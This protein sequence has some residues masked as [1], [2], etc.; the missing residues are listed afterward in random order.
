MS[1][2]VISFNRSFHMTGSSSSSSHAAPPSEEKK[3]KDPSISGDASLEEASDNSAAIDA[4]SDDV[5]FIIFSY[6][7]GKGQNGAMLQ[8]LREVSPRWYRI[9]EEMFLRDFFWRKMGTDPQKLPLQ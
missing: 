3:E 9:I 4:L 6:V 1:G 8:N 7:I 5:L 2:N